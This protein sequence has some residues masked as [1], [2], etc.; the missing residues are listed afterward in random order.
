MRVTLNIARMHHSLTCRTEKECRRKKGKV[1]SINAYV[2]NDE[3]AIEFSMPVA[4]F[5]NKNQNC[6]EV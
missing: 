2:L 3:I 5:F 1:N 4:L 6:S